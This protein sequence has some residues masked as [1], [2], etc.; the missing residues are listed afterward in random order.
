VEELL[1]EKGP[2]SHYRF[3]HTPSKTRD[4]ILPLPED[5]GLNIWQSEQR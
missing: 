2:T 5:R 1:F 4:S 3:V